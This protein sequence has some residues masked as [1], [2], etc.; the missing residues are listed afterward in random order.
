MN[1]DLGSRPMQHGLLKL[2]LLS[3][4][5]FAASTHQASAQMARDSYRECRLYRSANGDLIQLDER[6]DPERTI[7]DR[8][9]VPRLQ[10]RLVRN[11]RAVF[12]PTGTT[13]VSTWTGGT[14]NW[15]DGSM[16]NPTG[17]PNDNTADVFIDNGNTINSAVSL[18]GNFTV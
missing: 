11:G 17:A 6:R 1:T 9:V 5:F 12:R 7:Y 3:L 13:G 14:G 4:V 8:F 15:S 18:G 16:W 10:L 2:L